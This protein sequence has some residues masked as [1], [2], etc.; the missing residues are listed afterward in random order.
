MKF[1]KIVVVFCV[2]LAVAALFCACDK[3]KGANEQTTT[4]EVTTEAAT[5][6][7]FD[8]F[9][10]DMSQ[11]V[12]I[13]P[14]DYNELVIELEDKYELDEADLET[15]IEKL[16]ISKKT[17]LNDGAKVTN[18]ALKRGDSAFIFYKGMMDGKE[19][20]GGSNMGDAAPMELSIGSGTFIEGFEEGLIGVIPSE[21][22][23]ENP[24][25]LEL[26]FPENYGAEELA[27]KDVTFYV[28]VAW[29]VQYTIPEYDAE[30]ITDVLKWKTDETDVVAAHRKYLAEQLQ[31]SLDTSKESIIETTIWEILHKNVKVNKYPEGEV[32]YYYEAYIDE[33]EYLMN[34]Y[35]YMGYTYASLDEFCIAYLGLEKG[36]DWKAEIRKN[37]ENAVAQTL[38]VHVIADQQGFGITNEEY[39]AEIQANMDYYKNNGQNYSREEVI[40][41]VGEEMMKEAILYEKVVGF[42]KDNMTIEYVTPDA[43]A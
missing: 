1:N 4:G 36:A 7:R 12:S 14:A 21:T 9:A 37:A 35:G 19:F 26:K 18:A 3:N 24:K 31:D 40:E 25:V 32:E 5:E 8:Y 27:G 29:A 10:G 42:I 23:I 43:E 15:R 30:F 34:Y 17:A 38:I 13:N 2:L 20:E 39:E 11:Y 22:S 6:P 16:L 33:L 28:Y 41:M